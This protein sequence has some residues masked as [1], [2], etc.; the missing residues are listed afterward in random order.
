MLCAF[1]GKG[2][3]EEDR[4]V[5]FPKL[6]ASPDSLPDTVQVAPFLLA[7]CSEVLVRYLGWCLGLTVP[8][9]LEDLESAWREDLSQRP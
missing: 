5:C 8:C 6:S 7:F 4:V 2:S 1:G 9:R 3:L